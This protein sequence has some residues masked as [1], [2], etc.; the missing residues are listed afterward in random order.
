MLAGRIRQVSKLPRKILVEYEK[1]CAYSILCDQQGASR[2][3]LPLI[4]L[5]QR[6]QVSRKT[7]EAKGWSSDTAQRFKRLLHGHCPTVPVRSRQS[8]I[9]H[10][11]Y[12]LDT[13]I[14]TVSSLHI[15][16]LAAE[17]RSI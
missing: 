14:P 6:T 9:L 5:Q 10:S 4:S 13:V 8:S 11:I 7:H 15:L 2:V 1:N 12:N 3:R 16:R 17:Y